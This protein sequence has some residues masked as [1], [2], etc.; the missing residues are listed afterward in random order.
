MINILGLVLPKAVSF[1]QVN[2]WFQDEARVGQ[3]GTLT[4]IWVEKGTGPRVVRQQQFT[5]AYMFGAVFPNKDCAY[6]LLMLDANRVNEAP[7]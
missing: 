3:R 7:P 6:A 4:R 5:V 1:D 2:I